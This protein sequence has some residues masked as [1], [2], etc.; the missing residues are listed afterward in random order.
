MSIAAFIV[1]DVYFKH[2]KRKKIN[3]DELKH[4][5]YVEKSTHEKT[6]LRSFF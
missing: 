2:K 3:D 4:C 5:C 1:K 6:E